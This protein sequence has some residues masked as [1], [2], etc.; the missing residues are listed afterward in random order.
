[1]LILFEWEL[2]LVLRGCKQNTYVIDVRFA[3]QCVAY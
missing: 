1:M 3:A 2:Q